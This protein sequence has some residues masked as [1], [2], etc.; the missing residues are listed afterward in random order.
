MANRGESKAHSQ[1]GNVVF[2]F[3]TYE[4]WFKAANLSYVYPAE[5]SS[6]AVGGHHPST[7]LT[8]FWVKSFSLQF[9]ISQD[10]VFSWSILFEQLYLW[11]S[12]ECH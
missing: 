12:K 9:I 2:R 3:A 10:R 11:D 6:Y 8:D 7:D 1:K 4:L 5:G